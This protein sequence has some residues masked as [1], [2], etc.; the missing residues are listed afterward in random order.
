MINWC[1]TIKPLPIFIAIIFQSLMAFAKIQIFMIEANGDKTA[2]KPINLSVT[3]EKQEFVLVAKDG[4]RDVKA[5]VFT[6]T[7]QLPKSLVPQTATA[8]NGLAKLKDQTLIIS[9]EDIAQEVTLEMANGRRITLSVQRSFDKPSIVY[10]S[11]SKSFPEVN[12]DTSVSKIPFPV[13]V[14]CFFRPSGTKALAI[15]F[16]QSAEINSSTFF[17]ILGKGERWRLFEIPDSENQGGIIGNVYVNFANNTYK[18][19]VVAIN[20]QQ[21]AA[22][23]MLE[24]LQRENKTL[25]EALEELKKKSR[26]ILQK[27]RELNKRADRL[28]ELLSLFDVYFGFG[29]SSLNF[30]IEQTDFGARSL[31]D[32]AITMQLFTTSR[33]L[34]KSMVVDAGFS[35]TVP[36]SEKTDRLDSFSAYG[37]IGWAMTFGALDLEP[38]L[39]GA[40]RNY[41]HQA[42]GYSLISGH[43]GGGVNASYRLGDKDLIGLMIEVLPAGSKVI[44]S[45]LGYSLHYEHQFEAMNGW[46]LGGKMESISIGAENKA[47]APQK[48]SESRFIVYLSL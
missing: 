3:E 6:E 36:M 27:A 41:S 1:R 12:F 37:G 15:S 14:S 46:K 2:K 20:L 19:N 39:A 22:L 31:S 48:F 43:F 25:K 44:K 32:S 18:L 40:Y 28:E 34:W 10:D 13:G 38:R 45:H 42:S 33:P 5:L 11:C 21:L 47:G 35:T 23:K 9:G 30:K 17:D 7:I 29:N 4:D 8:Q 16:P 24:E 26:A